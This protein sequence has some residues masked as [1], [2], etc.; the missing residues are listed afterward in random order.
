[1]KSARISR[2]KVINQQSKYIS[3][4][5][6][7]LPVQSGLW[8]TLDTNGVVLEEGSGHISVDAISIHPPET[9]LDTVAARERKS[10]E[11]DRER[12]RGRERGRRCE[13]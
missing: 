10:L 13:L 6:V 9:V 5:P 3:L 2:F 12:E 7:V 1:M 8:L 4:L 11:R